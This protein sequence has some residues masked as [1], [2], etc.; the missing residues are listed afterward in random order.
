[1]RPLDASVFDWQADPL[2]RGA[3]SWVPV[4]GMKAEKE[5][6]RRVGPLFFAGEATHYGG[7]C[8]TVHG[9]L[10]TGLRAAAE[11]QASLRTR[12]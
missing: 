9:A 2:A 3:Y 8:G 1:M 5:L 11:L 7:A 12:R 6:A 10:E 4:G